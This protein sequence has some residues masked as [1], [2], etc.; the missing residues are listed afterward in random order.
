QEE[1][2]GPRRESI[3]EQA[4]PPVR[5]EGITAS[6]PAQREA[7]ELSMPMPRARLDL[8]LILCFATALV[9]F[10]TAYVCAWDVN[11]TADYYRPWDK[12]MTWQELTQLREEIE[13]F[14]QANGKLPAKLE[15]LDLVRIKQVQVNDAGQAVDVRGQPIQYQVTE[16]GYELY[17]FGR[18]GGGKLYADAPDPR[19]ELPTLWQFTTAPGSFGALAA[20]VLAGVV[21]LP[22]SLFFCQ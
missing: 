16:D 18:N 2:Q 1:G 13:R 15:D 8:R 5:T 4:P 17:S 6:V 3:T 10:F 21:A 22:P 19:G 7:L 14:R 12:V 20:C 11:R 9:V